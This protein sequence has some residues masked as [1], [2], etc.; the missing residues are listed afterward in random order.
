MPKYRGLAKLYFEEEA[1]Q[2]PLAN[3][4]DTQSEKLIKMEYYELE[5]TVFCTGAA[6]VSKGKG[7]EEDDGW[8]ISFVH[9]ERTNTSQVSSRLIQDLHCKL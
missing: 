5:E 4:R 6:F 2:F 9:N 7:F 1:T 8:I 3:Q